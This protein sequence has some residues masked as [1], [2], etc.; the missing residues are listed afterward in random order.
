MEFT[1]Y[2]LEDLK[3]RLD[4]ASYE[5]NNARQACRSAEAEE[6]LAREEYNNFIRGYHAY[7]DRTNNKD[8]GNG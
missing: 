1:Q 4:L 8:A 6:R 2:N 3:R 5:A 7:L